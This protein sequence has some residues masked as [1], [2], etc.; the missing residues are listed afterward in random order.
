MM[1]LACGRRS[2]RWGTWGRSRTP[3]PCASRAR[4][5]GRASWPTTTSATGC[6]PDGPP[7]APRISSSG[8]ASPPTSAAVDTAQCSSPRSWR[9]QQPP[10][11]SC[12]PCPRASA[13]RSRAHGGTHRLAAV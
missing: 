10:C 6:R 8:W 9:R 12:A 3:P 5:G 2:A 1:P 11:S 7:S 4:S 13:Q